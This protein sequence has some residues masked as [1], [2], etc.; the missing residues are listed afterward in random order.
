MKTKD[1]VI[2][3]HPKKI[4]SNNDALPKDTS[5]FDTPGPG[6]VIVRLRIMNADRSKKDKKPA[7]M[8]DIKISGRG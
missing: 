8:S 5:E 7:T 3:Q 2:E 4:A 6:P 1:I